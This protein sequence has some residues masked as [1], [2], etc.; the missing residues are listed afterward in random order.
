MIYI[1]RDFSKASAGVEGKF[2]IISVTQ[3]DMD[4][5]DDQFS[6]KFY[7]SGSQVI[8]DLGFDPDIKDWEYD[9]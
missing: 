1:T 2:Q 5:T 3:N 6:G 7:T 4:I 9:D 8:R